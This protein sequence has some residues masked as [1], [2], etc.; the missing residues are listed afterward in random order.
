MFKPLSEVQE[1]NFRA[2][3]RKNYIPGSR[4]NRLWHPVIQEECNLINKQN[5]GRNQNG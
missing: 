5:K 4:I 1:S 3:A 2:W